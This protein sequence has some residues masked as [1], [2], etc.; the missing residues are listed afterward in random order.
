MQIGSGTNPSPLPISVV[1]ALIFHDIV[2]VP[3]ANINEA[4]SAVFMRNTLNREGLKGLVSMED[5]VEAEKMILATAEH[6]LWKP[7]NVN[8]SMV[9]DADLVNLGTKD[10]DNFIKVQLRVLEEYSHVPVSTRTAG[11]K[12]LLGTLLKRKTVYRSNPKDYPVIAL[13][14]QN[15][16]HNLR[17]YCAGY[18]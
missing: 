3:G 7:T 6:F 8:T 13:W 10:Y 1:V 5:M 4:Y 2:Y 11:Q 12:R 15:A 16:Q 17:K 18:Y 9:M 14:E